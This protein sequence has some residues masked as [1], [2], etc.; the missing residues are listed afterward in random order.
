MNLLTKIV[1]IHFDAI[2]ESGEKSVF[3]CIWPD[4]YQSEAVNGDKSI[5]PISGPLIVTS[6]YSC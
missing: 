3:F 5:N 1:A 4:F 6:L 2:I